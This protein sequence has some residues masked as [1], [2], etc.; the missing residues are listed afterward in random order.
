MTKS[1]IRKL[2]KYH[3]ELL[4]R[5]ALANAICVHPEYL[6][7]MIGGSRDPGYRALKFLGIKK[8]VTVRYEVEQ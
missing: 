8:I 3:D 2:L 1:G 4:G 7:Q 5:E 6:G